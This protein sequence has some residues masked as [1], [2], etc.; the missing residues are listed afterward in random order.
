VNFSA[1]GLISRIVLD[2]DENVEATIDDRSKRSWVLQLKGAH[3]PR[4]L[5]RSLDTVAYDSSVRMVSTYQ[6]STKPHVVNVVANLNG[7]A[8][9]QLKRENGQLVWEIH[10]KQPPAARARSVATRTAGFA[11][12]AASLARSTPKQ[13]RRKARKRVSFDLKDAEIVN[14]LRLIAEASGENI[15]ASEDVKGKITLKLNNVP[16]DIALDT[17]LKTHGYDKVRH[18][19]ILRIAP[20]EKIRQEKENE[21]HRKKAEEQ[22]ED[23]LIKMITVN[24]A[25][26]KEIVAQLKPLLSGR[27]TVQTDERTNTIILEDIRTNV[28]RM[29]QLTKHLDKQ[30]P[31]VLI[32]AR[33]VE[34][35]SNF[36][37]ELGIQWGGVGQARAETGNPTGLQFPGEVQVNGAADGLTS[38]PDLGVTDPARF[39]V[40]LPAAIGPNIGGGVG[41]IFGSASG[42]Q[43]LN[44]RLTAMEA[45]GTGRIIS[46]PRI[47]T[48]DNRTAKIA[49]GVDIP[50]SVVSAA[51]VN[52]KF[53][54]ANLELEVTPHVTN[55]GS[56]LMNI[57]ASKNEPDFANVGAQGDPTIVKKFAQTEVLVRD[58]NTAVIGGIYT[59]NTNQRFQK[60]PFF[61]DLPIIGWFFKN[62]RKEDNRAELL[63]F[64]TPRII[65]RQESLMHSASVSS[66]DRD[67]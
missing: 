43:I 37:Q 13:S 28:D 33:I 12:E 22:V 15:V 30:T 57:L 31:Q 6:A 63:V 18:R 60:V 39:A 58:G 52:T 67:L 50:I 32:E 55:D 27:G 5:Q 8:T 66:P 11:S 46:S 19:N 25:S 44:L 24:Y 62:R 59:R 38:N 61:A 7:K 1:D 26:A 21:L 10:G 17:I 47:A 9:H 42:S 36:E 3:V 16:W 4:K 49:Q 45:E 65:N 41:F 40:N 2:V 56:V 23:T 51:G 34:A 54:P 14:V 53:I 64:I 29:V 48:L 20:A 35:S